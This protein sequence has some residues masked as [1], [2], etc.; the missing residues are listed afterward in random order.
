MVGEGAIAG[1]ATELRLERLDEILVLHHLRAA[2]RVAS[3]Y[4]WIVMQ[5]IRPVNSPERKGACESLL[6]IQMTEG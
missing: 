1:T 3:A 6:M 2:G 4:V 5:D